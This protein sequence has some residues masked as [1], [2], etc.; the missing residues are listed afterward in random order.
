MQ[1]S[2]CQADGSA[3]GSCG[4]GEVG[5][6]PDQV[7]AVEAAAV[8]FTTFLDLLPQSDSIAL[9]GTDGRKAL[10]YRH[11][12]SF[13]CGLD[14]AQFG[15]EIRSHRGAADE[16]DRLCVVI[17]N[18]PEAAACFVAMSQYCSYAP[19]NPNLTA[20]ELEFEFE[21]LPAKAVVVQ[22]GASNDIVLRVAR[23]LQKP[24]IELV[25]SPEEVGIFSL[26]WH[27]ESSL[28]LPAVPERIRAQRQDIALVLHTSGTTKKPK[29]V[30]L[31]HENI[32]VGAS[33]IA[34]T[35][36]LKPDDVNINMMPLY[37]I[38]GLAI[39]VLASLIAGASITATSG[40]DDENVLNWLASTNA[41]PN[42]YSAVP[43]MHQLLFE[44]AKR[45]SEGVT[46]SHSLGLIRNCSAAL[47][48]W[49]AS[50]MEKLFDVIVLPTYAMTES[51]PI[52]SNPRDDRRPGP[53][54]RR[55]TSVG[56]AAGPDVQVLADSGRRL[57]ADVEGEVCV[58]GSCVTAGYEYR[59]HM[60]V[61]NDPNV[62]AFHADGL[63]RTGD[64]GYVDKDGYLTLV[65][66]FKEII[67]R[68]GEKISPLAIE[69]VLQQHHA[70]ARLIVFAMPH[71][72]FGEV[73]G[74]AVVLRP[75]ATLTLQDLRASALEQGL[76]PQFL[77]E[78]II[79]MEKI[80]VGPTGKP[81]RINLAGPQKCRYTMQPMRLG[82]EQVVWRVDASGS[83]VPFG[84]GA[85][86]AAS[87]DNQAAPLCR[88]VDVQQALVNLICKQL[89]IRSRVD[90]ILESKVKELGFDSVRIV[91][92]QKALQETFNF[93]KPMHVIFGKTVREIGE[94]LAVES[95]L[96]EGNA[97]SSSAIPSRPAASGLHSPVE[98]AASSSSV[99]AF[100][101]IEAGATIGE[102]AVIG[103]HC[104]IEAGACVG[105]GCQIGRFTV[106]GA[107]VILGPRT[108]VGTHCSLGGSG[109]LE[110]GAD[111]RIESHCRLTATAPWK[112]V[113]GDRNQFHAQVILGFSPQ[114]FA[115][116][117]PVAG[118][119]VIG[120]D[121]VFREGVSVD[122]PCGC[123]GSSGEQAPV[124]TRI[125]SSCYIM[126]NAHIAHDCLLEDSVVLAMNV[127]LA[128]YVR[129]MH[130]SNI[131]VGAVVHQFSTVGPFCMIGM[132]TS[133]TRDPLPSTMYL[134]R[135]GLPGEGAVTVNRVGLARG[136]QLSD[137][138]IDS[139]EA[140]YRHEF[141]PT[142]ST[143]AGQTLAEKWFYKDFQA[144]DRH[145]AAQHQRRPLGVFL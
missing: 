58:K 82:D 108:M 95:C 74:A 107:R 88:H 52:C 30:P 90:F 23:S 66:R 86:Q 51:M 134:S 2:G 87:A 96:P 56:F 145:R 18:G 116:R 115:K 31:T 35:L 34:S 29:I 103:S 83:V 78:L 75:G 72:T 137:E 59:S 28:Q 1:G 13:A 15:I 50:H 101:I 43:T 114:D 143:L 111:C 60:G 22:A 42:W 33:C 97:S 63:L 98:A 69:E 122:T 3:G 109:T 94:M 5:K 104:V 71:E 41:A 40:F 91:G 16:S 140:F 32:C 24:V 73:P 89:Q 138:E 64:K 38:H 92:L 144:F 113:V 49:L 79:I 141:C 26:R 99:G 45:L 93:R 39:N 84:E 7:D 117:S 67:N 132:G 112:T 110:I 80:P 17:P 100:T 44:R 61:D 129:V 123:P 12:V 139:L 105:A 126:R 10:A 81:A 124:Y 53:P 9:R 133:V 76:S 120:D 121:N 19:L 77:P 128:G 54:L 8:T 6:I 27:P 127:Q 36:K 118:G 55:L 65:G 125:C 131:G 62:E 25:R 130:H 85:S 57:P 119:I 106:V 135:L 37:H 21:D 14:L 142:L 48:A 11:L 20:K 46:L 4:I 102:G 70:C 47:P 68:A 136:S